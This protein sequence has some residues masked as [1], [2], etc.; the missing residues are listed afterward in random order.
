M[1]SLCMNMDE[2]IKAG[3]AECRFISNLLIIRGELILGM[4][5]ETYL[6]DVL[7]RLARVG[8]SV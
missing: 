8:L 1:K 3:G 5:R 4:F 6:T 7:L 2:K